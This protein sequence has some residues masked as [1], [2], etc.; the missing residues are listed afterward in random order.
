MRHNEARSKKK[1]VVNIVFG[2]MLHEL[3]N[4][5]SSKKFVFFARKS[6]IMKL[7]NIV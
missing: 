4:C 3:N 7:G 5:A 6:L 2:K 1:L